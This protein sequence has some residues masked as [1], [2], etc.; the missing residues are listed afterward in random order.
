M[1]K[2]SAW[3]VA[4]WYGAGNHLHEVTFDGQFGSVASAGLKYSQQRR[5]VCSF[6]HRTGPYL[7]ALQL[8]RVDPTNSPDSTADDSTELGVSKNADQCVFL[9]Y[10][11]VKYRRFPP[12]KLAANADVEGTSEYTGSDPGSPILSAECTERMEVEL[13]TCTEPVSRRY[14]VI[15]YRNRSPSSACISLHQP[16]N[17]LDDILDY[18]LEVRAITSLGRGMLLIS[19]IELRRCNGNC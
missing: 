9:N 15:K 8:N 1:I 14:P 13:D 19:I 6:E 3:A 4:A 10:Y 2:T 7:P 5:T 11:K 18:I 17:P 12:K 16:H